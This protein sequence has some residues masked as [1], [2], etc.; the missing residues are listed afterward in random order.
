MPGLVPV[1][2]LDVGRGVREDWSEAIPKDLGANFSVDTMYYSMVKVI[3]SILRGVSGLI[4]G[5]E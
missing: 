3:Q 1:R 4:K 5:Q 2:L